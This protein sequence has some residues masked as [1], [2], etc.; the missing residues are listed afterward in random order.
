[1]SCTAGRGGKTKSNAKCEVRSTEHSYFVPVRCTYRCTFK[2]GVEHRTPSGRIC[3]CIGRQADFAEHRYPAHT[4]SCSIRFLFRS[5]DVASSTTSTLSVLLL[6]Y[7]CTRYAVRSS[8]PK[9][10]DSKN[11]AKNRKIN[12]HIT[13]SIEGALVPR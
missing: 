6:L 13:H 2:Q 3:F 7:Y 4:L 5:V 10:F 12:S 8:L 1:M 9:I 11:K